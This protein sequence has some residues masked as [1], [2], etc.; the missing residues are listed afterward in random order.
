AASSVAA[1]A[2]LARLGRCPVFHL[3]QFPAI[4]LFALAGFDCNGAELDAL[5]RS[6]R[7]GIALK[8]TD[9][10]E[11]RVLEARCRAVA[12]GGGHRVPLRYSRSLQGQTRRLT[13][14][15]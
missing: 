5:H 1:V 15:E 10:V 4:A 3:V 11:A 2:A 7:L 12:N 6:P 8:E 14:I 13:G 9:G